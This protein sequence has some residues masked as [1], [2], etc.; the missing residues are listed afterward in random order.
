VWRVSDD[1][2]AWETPASAPS[3]PWGWRTRIYAVLVALSLVGVIAFVV[4][5]FVRSSSLDAPLPGNVRLGFFGNT[6]PVRWTCS[7][8]HHHWSL[9]YWSGAVFFVVLT[10]LFARLFRQK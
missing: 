2:E 7:E 1:P 9:P 3:T 6:A 4:M 10:A 8:G 5:G